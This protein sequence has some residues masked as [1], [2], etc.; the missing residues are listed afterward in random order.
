MY[1]MVTILKVFKKVD[2]N[3]ITTQGKNIYHSY[4]KR[5]RCWGFPGGIVVKTLPANERDMGSIPELGKSDP[6]EKEMATHSSFL[7]W[8]I[9]WRGEPG[10]L[11]SIGWKELDI[12]KELSMHA[13]RLNLLLSLYCNVCVLVTQSYPT[14]CQPMDYN[15]PGSSVHGILPARILEWVAIPYSRGSSR[16]RNQ[17]WVSFIAGRF[18][19]L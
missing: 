18:F 5:Q 13:W 1:S 2:L 11:Q 17:T 7:A 6:P 3:V 9:S 14:L 19:T 4:V 8:K 15:P 10:G 16:P 12:T